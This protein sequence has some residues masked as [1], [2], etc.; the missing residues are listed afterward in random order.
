MAR[1]SRRPTWATVASATGAMAAP[2]VEAGPGA[3][4]GT[5]P[6]AGPRAAGSMASDPVIGPRTVP[7]T[8]RTVTAAR[9]GRAAGRSG[10]AAGTTPT[11]AATA[12]GASW[13]R[14]RTR[15]ASAR[16][17]AIR[18]ATTARRE[19]RWRLGADSRQGSSPQLRAEGLHPVG[20]ARRGGR[21]RAAVAGVLR[22]LR[23]GGG[24]QG[25]RG[26]AV[27]DGP[28]AAGQAPRRGSR[29]R[30][31][32]RPPRAEQPQGPGHVIPGRMERRWRIGIRDRRDERS[33][34]WSVVGRP[35]VGR[36]GL[37]GPNLGGPASGRQSASGLAGASGQEGATR[38]ET[39]KF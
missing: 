39:S 6:A 7:A 38:S 28:F 30:R 9:A 22:R 35:V 27:G 25:G 4:R 31:V 13:A 32:G 8:T 14:S 23:R 12:T 18:A 34:V 11:I 17:A 37:G 3:A 20:F 24:G 1:A 21:Q 5:S 29:R 36:P 19:D 33:V 16:T 15:S 2:L 26:D 10:R